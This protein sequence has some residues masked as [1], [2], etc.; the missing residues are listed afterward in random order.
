MDDVI[1]SV[2]RNFR[3][4]FEGVKGVHSPQPVRPA[5]VGLENN[6]V[7]PTSQPESDGTEH[8]K[9][10]FMENYNRVHMGEKGNTVGKEKRDVEGDEEE[11]EEEDGES[12]SDVDED[13]D[14][15][16]S[17]KKNFEEMGHIEENIPH[18]P[19]LKTPPPPPSHI[20]SLMEDLERTPRSP[21]IFK[22]NMAEVNAIK[23]KNKDENNLFQDT[24]PGKP[25]DFDIQMKNSTINMNL[26]TVSGYDEPRSPIDF[27]GDVVL[28]NRQD[29]FVQQIWEEVYKI[30]GSCNPSMARNPEVWA[31]PAHIF[32]DKFLGGDWANVRVEGQ[33]ATNLIK[34]KLPRTLFKR[35]GRITEK[36]AME[37]DAVPIKGKNVEKNVGEYKPPAGTR[38]EKKKKAE[39]KPASPI[40][41][42]KI[43]K[44]LPVLVP[45]AVKKT[46]EKKSD[47]QSSSGKGDIQSRTQA[48][49]SDKPSL[50]RVFVE[51]KENLVKRPV[52]L[53][54]KKGISYAQIV[55]VN[56]YR[57]KSGGRSISPEIWEMMKEMAGAYPNKTMKDIEDMVDFG[58][59][60]APTQSKGRN[61]SSIRAQVAMG[62]SKGPSHKAAIFGL[63][64]DLYPSLFKDMGRVVDGMNKHLVF[65]HLR[66]RVQSGQLCQKV[67]QFYLNNVPTTPEFGRIKESLF[68][69]LDIDLEGN[70]AFAPQSKAH[71]ILKGFDFY[72]TRYSKRPEDILTGERVVEMMTSV[73]QFAGIE[74]VRNPAVV[75]SKGSNN[76]AVVFM[77]IWDS[78]N[79]INSRDLVNKVYHI[80]GKLIKVEYARPREFVPQCQR[81]WN[82]NHGMKV[83]RLNHIKCARC[84]AGHQIKN[85]NHY[86]TCCSEIGKQTDNRVECA[87]KIRCLNCKGEHVANDKKCVYKR[88]ENN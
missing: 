35:E 60:K 8:C 79:G 66:I 58:E 68:K 30:Y 86:A 14:G 87:H 46:V 19:N 23:G 73:Q 34:H 36:D 21:A 27:E 17:M 52:P 44:P 3:E 71:L 11:E 49:A 10:N 18:A 65:N 7:I 1:L 53:P 80:G 75:R 24:K 42:S 51:N 12:D 74:C 9:D 81:C 62:V 5:H 84:G 33:N 4:A 28:K 15:R 82:W 40:K 48:K 67:V 78:Q 83:C 20:S 29:T 50:S 25:E 76:M 13:E 54:K 2:Q 88:H 26:I 85:H 55:A 56:K 38:A 64:N 69:T 59:E 41:V 43:P 57:I 63:N 61:V 6:D 39:A 45:V 37:V 70:D 32:L 72:T 22:S 31:Q 77:D 47:I 16:T